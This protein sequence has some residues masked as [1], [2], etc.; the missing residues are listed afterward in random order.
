MTSESLEFFLHGK[1]DPLVV[2]AMT[3]DAMSAVLERIDALP[4]VGQ[5]VF[6]GEADQLRGESGEDAHE[7]IDIS[8]T[9][10]QL[11][12]SRHSHVH[13]RAHRRIDVTVYFNG[14]KRYRFSPATTVASLTA[15]AK[16]KFQVDPSS[17]GDLVLALRPT[18]VQ[19]RP[20]QHLGELLQAGS[21]VLE[22]DLVR[23]V[24]PQG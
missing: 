20:T 12:V 18:G 15:W 19:P 6:L 17:S 7:P 14:Q 23:E 9:L 21:H 16:E 8:L 5:F 10:R 3:T 24:T 1:G 11:G 13:T 4:G 2:S 22:F